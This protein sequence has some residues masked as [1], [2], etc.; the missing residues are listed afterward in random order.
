MTSSDASDGVREVEGSLEL[1]KGPLEVKG[2]IVVGMNL[3]VAFEVE[4]DWVLERVVG[5]ECAL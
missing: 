1:K 4:E 2:L 5:R 3:A